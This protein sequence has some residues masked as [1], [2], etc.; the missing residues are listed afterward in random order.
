MWAST[1]LLH[2]GLLGLPCAQKKGSPLF[3]FEDPNGT[4]NSPI[5]KARWGKK[6]EMETFAAEP[7]MTFYS[8]GSTPG[9]EFL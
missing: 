3:V 4:G 2:S 6:S 8:A 5:Q 9:S 1:G 7:L